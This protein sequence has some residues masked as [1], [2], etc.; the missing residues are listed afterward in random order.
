[1]NRI[2]DGSG[3]GILFYYEILLSDIVL[4]GHRWV[5]RA[6]MRSP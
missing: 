6:T 2:L 5:G 1:M 4:T 3:K